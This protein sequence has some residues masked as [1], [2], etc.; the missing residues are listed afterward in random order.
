M[1]KTVI[2]RVLPDADSPESSIGTEVMRLLTGD[3]GKQYVGMV[4]GRIAL[5]DTFHAI[6]YRMKADNVETQIA[7]VKRLYGVTWIAEEC[8]G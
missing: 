1:D 5:T 6:R 8:E 3:D 4:D 2:I 7:E